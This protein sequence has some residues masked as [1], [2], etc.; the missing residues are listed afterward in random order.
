MPQLIYDPALRNRM[1]V[2]VGVSE[3]GT[4]FERIYD[5]DPVKNY[6][7][8]V[9]SNAPNCLGV[10]KAGDRNLPVVTLDSKLFFESMLG[11]QQVPRHGA[12]RDAYDAA[13]F[14]LV[15]QAAGKPDLIC[16]AG[17]DLWLGDRAVNRYFPRI[18][19]VHPGD[20]TKGY[21]GYGWVPTA[22]AILAGDNSVKS[23]LFFADKTDDEGPVLIQS[24][25]LILTPWER[26]L[27]D[28]RNFAAKHNAKTLKEFRE[29]AEAEGRK[30]LA[31]KLKAVSRRIQNRL[32]EQGDWKI[33]PFAVHFLIGDGRTEINEQGTVY[34]DGIAMPKKGYQVDRYGFTQKIERW[35]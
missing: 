12:E 33:Y 22:R 2:A 4:N 21:K 35:I 30:E 32:K 16:L 1:T 34:V 20:T 26:E 25:S 13:I 9:F 7:Y 28:V 27:F 5:F 14:T 6:N 29:V 31:D 23:T 3:T 8:I 15:E 10:K 17:Y 24:A 18:L 19:N 11:L